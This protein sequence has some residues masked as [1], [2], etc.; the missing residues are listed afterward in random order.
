MIHRA[1]Q[2]ASALFVVAVLIAAVMSATAGA[3]AS[4]LEWP[5]CNNDVPTPNDGLDSAAIGLTKSE[6]TSLYGQGVEVQDG[7]HYQ[8]DGYVL[9]A[10]GC[11]IIVEIEADSPFRDRD[12]ARELARTLLPTDAIL[13]GFWSLGNPLGMGDVPPRDAEEWISGSLA[14]RYRLLGQAQ[15]GSILVV[16]Y[17]AADMAPDRPLEFDMVERIELRTAQ[18]PR[19][20]ATPTSR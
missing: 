2:R 3:S 8:R 7:T 14:N 13:A 19:V 17:L 20:L 5:W 11:D 12:A 4:Q 6:L 10:T 16:Y 15:G 9:V 18:L 1:L